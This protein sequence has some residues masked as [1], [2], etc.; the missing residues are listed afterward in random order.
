MRIK[1]L[2][3]PA[4]RRDDGITNYEVRVTN[5]GLP[6]IIRTDCSAWQK[7]ATWLMPIITLTATEDSADQRIDR[8][9]AATLTDHSR[10]EIQ[11]WIE[12]KRITIEGSASK[13]GHRLVAG[14]TIVIDTPESA[15]PASVEAQDI[16][17]NIVYEDDDLLVINKPAGLVVHPA[18]GHKDGTVVNAVLHYV[19]DLEGVGGEQR[20]G[21][22]H[23]LDKDTSGL[24]VI[25]KHDRAHRN[26]QAQFKE[27]T[28][29]K[30]YLA[31]VDG[32]MT[33]IKGIISAPI[34][35]HP[36]DRKRF[37]VL[38]G[39]YSWVDGE[40]VANKNI[41]DA[42]T[43]YESLTVY[44]SRVRGLENTHPFTLL[45]VVL[46]TGRTHQIRV[47]LAWLKHPVIGDTFYG[48]DKPRLP[49]QRQFLHAHK[50]RFNLPSTGE[51]KEFIVPLPEELEKL[52]ASM[53]V[54]S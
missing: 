1:L 5:D 29:Y 45:R 8:W 13:A 35:R 33:P 17:L 9:L 21:L 14:E 4:K 3:K 19:P 43:E 2:L 6:V 23:R 50:L 44:R 41:K 47:H 25:A 54:S 42:T 38:P 46:H 16:P 36:K 18:P 22:V 28:V 51:E 48:P 27:R 7:G 26:L 49:L 10:S 30:E 15:K 52:I 34:G 31:L 53:E 12:E 11:R 39:A 24:L 32:R 20:P 40:L 37:A